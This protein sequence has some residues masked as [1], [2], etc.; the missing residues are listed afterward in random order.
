MLQ[1]EMDASRRREEGQEQCSESQS[2]EGRR[3]SMGAVQALQGE[4]S[5]LRNVLSA[6][7][8]TV[9]RVVGRGPPAISEVLPGYEEARRGGFSRF[10]LR[11][12]STVLTFVL[13]RRGPNRG[14]GIGAE[15]D[16]TLPKS[17]EG[18]TL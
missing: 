6:M 12:V 2:T 5:A 7:T 15:E 16:G 18:W 1:R 3:L 4:I 17:R 13:T 11:A 9:P 10:P 8:T 14:H